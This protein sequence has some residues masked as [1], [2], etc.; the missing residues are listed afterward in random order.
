[1][2]SNE[3]DLRRTVEKQNKTIKAYTDHCKRLQS[4]IDKLKEE[5]L[6]YRGY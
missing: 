6:K 3:D 1:M 4:E 5:L 2:T